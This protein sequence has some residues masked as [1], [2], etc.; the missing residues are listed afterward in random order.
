MFGTFMRKLLQFQLW[1]IAP[2]FILIDW[3]CTEKEK[4]SFM[5]AR[6]PKWPKNQYFVSYHV[7]LVGIAPSFF[8][9]MIPNCLGW[10]L[11]TWEQ[12]TKCFRALQN[13]KFFKKSS[14]RYQKINFFFSLYMISQSK[15]T[16]V[17]CFTTLTG[18]VCALKNQTFPQNS[19]SGCFLENLY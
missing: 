11:T 8:K 15:Q 14:F 18:A 12:L 16:W 17:Q 19:K 5:S 9:R 2:K 1:N 6:H 13:T 10:L 7:T 3:S 4:N